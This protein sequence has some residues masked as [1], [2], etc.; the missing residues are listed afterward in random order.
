M[1]KATAR[2]KAILSE[3]PQN[4]QARPASNHPV[5]WREKDH[6]ISEVRDGPNT[7]LGKRKRKN[8]DAGESNPEKRQREA[9]VKS[10]QPPPSNSLA[11]SPNA[12]SEQTGDLTP[13]IKKIA[14]CNKTP[15]QKRVLTAICQIP[16]GQYTTYAAISK[17]LSSCPR[18]VGNA[19][20]NN[21]FAPQVPCHRVLAS[22]GGI[23]GFKGS[24]GRNGEEGLNDGLKRKLLADEGVR[25][26]S[27][28]KVFGRVWE[29]FK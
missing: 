4:K 20:R 1:A 5:E 16:P 25:F 24:W 7:N 18:A 21:P 17:S 3:M 12:V 13:W 10:A 23:G 14:L 15:F 19:L 29:E 9:Q 27:G 6:S 22:D 26:S 11:P 8:I 2:V 28:G